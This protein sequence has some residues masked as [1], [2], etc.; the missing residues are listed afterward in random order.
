[1]RLVSLALLALIAVVQA[2]LWFGKGS[3][4]RVWA[5]RDDLAQA[6]ARN[7]ESAER[8]ARLSAEVDDLREGLEIVEERARYELGMVKPNEIY[9]HIDP[10]T[11]GS[12]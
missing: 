1:M 6:Q 7:A 11:G 3:L 12:P 4:P 8:N 10:R 9:V 5:L 2:E